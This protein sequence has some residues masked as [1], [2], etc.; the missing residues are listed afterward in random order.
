MI[1]NSIDPIGV[2]TAEV[3]YAQAGTAAAK[4]FSEREHVLR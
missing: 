2:A 4:L 3:Q 1:V